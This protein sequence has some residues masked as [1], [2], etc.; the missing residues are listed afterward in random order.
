MKDIGSARIYFFPEVLFGGCGGYLDIV[1]KVG[2]G[3]E[4]FELETDGRAP[5]LWLLQLVHL[6]VLRLPE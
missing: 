1:G 2:G 3:R 5:P 6:C 4:R